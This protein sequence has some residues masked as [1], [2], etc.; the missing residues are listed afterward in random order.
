MLNVLCEGGLRGG[1]RVRGLIY[2]KWRWIFSNFCMRIHP[3]NM[4][5]RTSYPSPNKQQLK[6]MIFPDQFP[7]G[8]GA[9]KFNDKMYIT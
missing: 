3:Q 4:N 7:S 9:I 8:K 5:E 6:K 1:M 2:G